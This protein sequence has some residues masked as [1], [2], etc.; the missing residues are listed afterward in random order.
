M[1]GQNCLSTVNCSASVSLTASNGVKVNVETVRAVAPTRTYVDNNTDTLTLKSESVTINGGTGGI[2]ATGSSSLVSAAD[3]TLRTDTGSG[4]GIGAAATPLK[5]A[6]ERKFDFQPNGPFS[7]ELQGVG[8]NRLDMTIGALNAGSYI[9]STLTGAG[10]NVNADADTSKV[11]LNTMSITS[12]FDAKVYQS[13]P[14]ISL[15]VPNGALEAS[16]ILIPQGDVTGVTRHYQVNS[17]YPYYNITYV[18]YQEYA[19][20]NA[21]FS[22]A[23]NLTVTNFTRASS[24]QSR[25]QNTDFSSYNGSVLLT[26]ANANKDYVSVSAETGVTIAT[27]L[28]TQGS[29]DLYTNSGGVT[30]EGAVNA[31][32]YLSASVDS[33]DVSIPGSVTANGGANIYAYSG[34]VSMPGTVTSNNGPTSIYASGG[35]A[36]AGSVAGQYGVN[37]TADSGDVTVNSVAAA[38]GSVTLSANG[39]TSVVGAAQDGIA[40]E[41]TAAGNV[42]ITAHAIGAD[43]IGGNP[44]NFPLDIAA[45]SVS[46]T[47][48]GAGSTIGFA[49][50]PVVASAP[51][52]TINASGNFNVSTDAVMS[53]DLVNLNVTASPSAVGNNGL[54]QVTSNGT[55]YNFHSDGT[56]FTLG[57]TN[58]AGGS[59]LPAN[60]LAGGGLNFT[61][62]TGSVNLAS[63]DFSASGADLT[64]RTNDAGSGNVTQTDPTI[65]LGSGSLSFY[66][67]GAVAVQNINAGNLSVE[68]YQAGTGTFTQAVGSTVSLGS[69][70]MTVNASGDVNLQN[71]NAGSLSVTANQPGVGNVTQGVGSTIQLGTGTLSIYADGDVKLEAANAGGMDVRDANSDYFSN[72]CL[73]DYAGCGVASFTANQPLTDTANGGGMWSVSARGSITTGNL[74]VERVD[75]RTYG[76]DSSDPQYAG[77]ITTGSIDAGTVSLSAGSNYYYSYNS[78]PVLVTTGAIGSIRR[79][80]TVQ[81]AAGNDYYYY[82]NPIRVGT[83]RVHRRWERDDCRLR[84]PHHCFGRHRRDHARRL[85]VAARGLRVLGR[86]SYRRQ[87]ADSGWKHHGVGQHQ[88]VQ[89]LQ[90]SDSD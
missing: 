76:Q 41:V 73:G 24:A 82:Y 80:D 65:A 46:L 51:D 58:I 74:A 85:R 27:S 70:S 4:A 81:I 79:P 40:P 9:G 6:V 25:P 54:A 69:G 62:S 7:V 11:T 49:G 22:A 44:A 61:A 15:Y 34:N 28:T 55:L 21:S 47:T 43:T 59:P 29:I 75:F 89:L 30:I 31:G 48:F 35:V 26:T 72:G 67:Q 33:G 50:R 64:V 16:S 71:I 39:P 14:S 38:N 12:G 13:T 90:R 63:I 84:W 3:V 37:I 8:P 66:A 77:N 10:I 60:Q 32:G 36:I 52:L 23:N 87:P 20:L 19:T 78:W 83:D 45:S 17:G 88:P 68:T 86:R 2:F 57:G 42:S 5:V 1:T 18:P 53:V 56:N